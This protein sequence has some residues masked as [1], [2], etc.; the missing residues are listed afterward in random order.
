M[1]YL[2]IMCP[3]EPPLDAFM[4]KQGGFC[5]YSNVHAGHLLILV[6]FSIQIYNSINNL[7]IKCF[8]VKY[9]NSGGSK[10]HDIAFR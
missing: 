6:R 8:D 5:L 7:D 9:F 2:P 1:Q 3:L 10:A 4:S